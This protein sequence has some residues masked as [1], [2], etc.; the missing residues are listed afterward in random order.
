MGD[1]DCMSIFAKRSLR[2][3]KHRYDPLMKDSHDGN[4]VTHL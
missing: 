4:E 3:R 2:S 1:E